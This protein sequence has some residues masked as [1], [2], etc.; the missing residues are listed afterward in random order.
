MIF[1]LLISCKEEIKEMK[2]QYYLVS[3]ERIGKEVMRR[4]W[5]KNKYTLHLFQCF[6]KKKLGH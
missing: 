2:K 3:K 6:A 4:Q 1:I 5:V